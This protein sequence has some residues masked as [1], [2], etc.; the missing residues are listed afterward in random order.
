MLS[1]DPIPGEMWYEPE[2]GGQI[3]GELLHEAEIGREA[4]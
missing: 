1:S 2:I 4:P 3:S